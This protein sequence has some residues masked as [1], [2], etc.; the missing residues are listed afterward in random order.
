MKR[1]NHLSGRKTAFSNLPERERS[2]S[3]LAK[4][5]SFLLGLAPERVYLHLLLLVDV[6]GSYSPFSNSPHINAERN[7]LCDTIRI[8]EVIPSFHLVSYPMVPGLSSPKLIRRDCPVLS[9]IYKIQFGALLK[10]I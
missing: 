3:L 10:V 5:H 1:G 6:G 9:L 7:I 8:T 4:R 2:G